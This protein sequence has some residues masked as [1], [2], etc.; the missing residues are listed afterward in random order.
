MVPIV[1]LLS[2]LCSARGQV[3]QPQR[4]VLTQHNDIYRSGVYPGETVLR[5]SSVSAKSFGKIFARRVVGQ[6]W[7]Q[8]LYVRG[9]P[10]QGRLRNMVYVATSENRVYGFDADDRRP[11]EETPPLLF[12]FL[13]YAKPIGKQDFYTI[14]PSNGVISTPIIDLGNPPDPGKGTLYVVAKK[15][16]DKFHIF[17]LDLGSLAI[18]PNAAGQPTDVIVEAKAPGQRDGSTTT[19][20]FGDSDHLNRPALL[21]SKNHLIVA[22]GSGP[23]GDWDAPKTNYHGWVLSYSLPNLAQTGVFL[24][25]PSTDTGTGGVWQAGSGLAADDQGNI[26]FITGNGRFQ[27][28]HDR[29]DLANALSSWPTAMAPCTSPIGTRRRRATSWK[30]VICISGPPDQG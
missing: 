30:R 13:G 18:R 9:V 25:T 19:V 27:S 28:T 17:A 8:P 26:Y 15:Q 12:R 11:D 14:L 20:S 16:D 4:D 10:V 1:F 7:G 2:E 24:T 29:P 22:F 21:V 6:I 3:R 23:N 5:P